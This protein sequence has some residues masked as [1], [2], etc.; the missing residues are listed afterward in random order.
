MYIIYLIGGNMEASSEASYLARIDERVKEAE[1]SHEI[2]QSE[3]Q[4]SDQKMKAIII[5]FL[6]NGCV[7]EA[8]RY[9]HHFFDPNTKAEIQAAI[10][11][12][13]DNRQGKIKDERYLQ[14]M[15]QKVDVVMNFM[16]KPFLDRDSKFK[17][18]AS[19]LLDHGYTDRAFQMIEYYSKAR[20]ELLPAFIRKGM[21]DL[22]APLRESPPDHARYLAEMQ[23]HLDKA[24][25]LPEE[26]S[27]I[28]DGKIKVLALHLIDHG[29]REEA[30]K[31]IPKF[32]MHGPEKWDVYMALI[33]NYA[34]TGDWEGVYKVGINS[35][36]DALYSQAAQI[37][38]SAGETE[39]ADAVKA[40][41]Q[42]RHMQNWQS[43]A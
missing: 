41:I 5:D 11:S 23:Q 30:W 37:L 12:A 38:Y 8:E 26:M 19:D 9:K 29:Y 1:K 13:Q 27:D 16:L 36:E 21:E 39:K 15:Q 4:E 24:A 2:P 17:E 18:I 7:E 3:R 6:E 14:Q 32:A 28:C 34:Q 33:D 42:P 31:A 35:G 10:Q 20:S 22:D 40:K 25:A 43:L